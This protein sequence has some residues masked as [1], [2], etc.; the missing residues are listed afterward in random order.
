MDEQIKEGDKDRN[1]TKI[2]INAGG[3][4]TKT[5]KAVDG[6]TYFGSDDGSSISVI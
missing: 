6:V 4:A 2:E 1:G 3:C 5:K